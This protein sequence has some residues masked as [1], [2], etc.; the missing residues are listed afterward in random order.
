MIRPVALDSADLTAV[1]AIMEH[2]VEHT[3]A[4]FNEIPPT[5]DDW[6]QRHADIAA[7]GLPFLVAETAGGVVGFAYVTPW[8]PQSAYRHTVENSVYLDPAATGRGVGTALLA[9]L[10]D[11]ASAAGCRQMIAVIADTGHPASAALHRRLGFTD[12]GRLR[13]V[14]HKHGRWID[15]QFMQRD[16]VTG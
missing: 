9:E 15:T 2:Y 4:T 3:V 8:R 1:A 5:V 16:L 12:A 10:V 14:G 7:R 11:R 6:V 13:A